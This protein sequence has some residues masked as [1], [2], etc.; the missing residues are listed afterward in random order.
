[1]APG[2]SGRHH[3]VCPATARFWGTAQYGRCC[4]MP[5][6]RVASAEREHRL[7]TVLNGGFE[8]L[9]LP[10]TIRV[11]D[12]AFISVA[13]ASRAQV[14]AGFVKITPDFVVEVLSPSDRRSRMQS[15][16]DD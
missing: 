15:K 3:M 16:L 7:G 12:I 6:C 1:M 13:R 9:A 4:G 8:L 2:T 14:P 10:R 11:P 5:S